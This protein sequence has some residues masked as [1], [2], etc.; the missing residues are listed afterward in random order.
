[1]SDQAG[2]VAVEPLLDLG[3]EGFLSVPLGHE[4]NLDELVVIEGP[5]DVGEGALGEAS[6][7]D[8]EASAQALVDRAN[9]L[10]GPDNITVILAER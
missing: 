1:M 8:L 3:A 6:G 9:A 10:G 7:A 2:E 4:S 5:I